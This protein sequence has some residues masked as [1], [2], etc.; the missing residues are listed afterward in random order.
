MV[1]SGFGA[2]GPGRRP[3]PAIAVFC[4]GQGTNLQ[5]LLDAARRGALRARIALLISDRPDALALTR[6]SVEARYIN[7]KAFPTRAA[8]ERALIRLCD[9]HGVRL[10][11]LAG[12]MRLL[13]PVFVRRFRNRLLNV[14]PALLPAFPGASAIRDAL[15]WGA[16][17]TGVTVHFVDEEM[18]H[19][20]IILQEAV[21]IRPGDT[22]ARLLS[23]VHR[24]EHRLYPRAIGLVLAGRV[25][26][27]GRKVRRK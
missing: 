20:P 1:G 24:V 4:S 13:T 26:V 3:R 6:A 2:R 12:Y 27:E 19:G 10:V 21:P 17:V 5:A 11:C 9:E 22:E 7:P 14:H 8:Y 18:D 16:K 15:A 23:R 25:R